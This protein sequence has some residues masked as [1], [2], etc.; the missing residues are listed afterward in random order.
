MNPLLF[1]SAGVASGTAVEAASGSALAGATAL[2]IAVTVAAAQWHSANMLMGA[3]A[4][5]ALAATLGDTLATWLL[6]TVLVTSALS[7]A[8]PIQNRALSI[9]VSV[10]LAIIFLPIFR[11]AT[12]ALT[13]VLRSTAAQR[14]TVRL[15]RDAE[16]TTRKGTGK[17]PAKTATAVQ[18]PDGKRVTIVITAPPTPSLPQ[19]V[20][21]W[22]TKTAK[23]AARLVHAPPQFPL[24]HVR[25]TN[26]RQDVLSLY[27]RLAPSIDAACKEAAA[28]EDDRRLIFCGRGAA[29][30]VALL[31]ALQRPGS[32]CVML[33]PVRIGDRTLSDLARS[34]L[35]HLV[36]VRKPLP[37]IPQPLHRGLVPAPGEQRVTLR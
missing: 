3:A 11:L 25:G 19:S 16:R 32:S 4:G 27:E 34:L 2:G 17:A 10:F 1:A 18:N 30:A 22:S 29:G 15:A 31:A 20:Y 8:M 13:G 35:G 24:L 33:D 26:V 6:T 12:A 5:G 37:Q 36:V 21:L 28:T 23:N 7:R 9:A 14:E